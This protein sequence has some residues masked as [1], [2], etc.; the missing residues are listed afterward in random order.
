MNQCHQELFKSFGLKNTLQRDLV[1]HSL[2]D[3]VRPITAEEI[4][5][6]LKENKHDISLST[7]YRILDIFLQ[8]GIIT[9]LILPDSDSL[10]YELSKKEHGHHLI[11]LKCK[12]IIHIPGC[13]LG[14]YETKIT[15]EAKF[16]VIRHQL[17]LYG[18]CEDC[19][20]KSIHE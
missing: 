10:L 1:Y 8:K 12:R 13:P 20:K 2:H 18:Y 4:H 14:N 7:I 19:I 11:C 15:E 16:K 3:I 5:R 17:D 9:K 6:Y